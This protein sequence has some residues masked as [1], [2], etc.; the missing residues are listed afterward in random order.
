MKEYKIGDVVRISGLIFKH[1]PVIVTYVQNN[2]ISYVSLSNENIRG[3][4][5]ES[6]IKELLSKIDKSSVRKLSNKALSML[7]VAN[8]FEAKI[9]HLRRRYE[10]M[11]RDELKNASRDS[12][13][14]RLMFVR[15][16]IK[17]KNIGKVSNK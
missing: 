2:T 13:A 11:T 6:R 5:D 3:N 10:S 14:A 9:E 7:L 1:R 15:K 4:V 16:F 8:Y 17:N 12:K